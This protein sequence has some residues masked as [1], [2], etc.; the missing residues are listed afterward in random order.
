M[1]TFLNTL[2]TVSRHGSWRFRQVIRTQRA[3]GRTDMSDDGLADFSGDDEVL[4]TVSRR[5]PARGCW[6]EACGEPVPV[7]S[8]SLSTGTLYA[9]AGVVEALF[10]PEAMQCVPPGIYDARI[11]R[12]VGDETTEAF[13]EVLEFA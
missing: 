5:T 13:S 9:A 8:A 6:D 11:L 1:P 10:P 12:T 7:L 2:G 3:D 4:L